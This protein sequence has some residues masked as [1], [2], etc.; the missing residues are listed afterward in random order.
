MRTQLVGLPSGCVV[1]LT[2]QCAHVAGAPAPAPRPYVPQTCF[3]RGFRVGGCVA[4]SLTRRL[5]PEGFL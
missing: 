4:C 5:L 1:V 2:G 3:G